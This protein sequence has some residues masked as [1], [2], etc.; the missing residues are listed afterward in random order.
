EP[1]RAWSPPFARLPVAR[2][3][4][5]RHAMTEKIFDEVWDEQIIEPVI[6]PERYELAA[7]PAYHFELPRRDFFKVLGGG[8]LIVLTLKDALGQQE[9]GGG[10]R[11]G[12]GQAMPKEI[13]AWLHI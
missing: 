8:V 12:G 2:K 1:T 3:Q 11:R 6:E 5:R 9:S 4:R 13:S 7:G 10:Q